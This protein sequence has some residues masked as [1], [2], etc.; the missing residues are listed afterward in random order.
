VPY[1]LP[2]LSAAAWNAATVGREPCRSFRWIYPPLLLPVAAF[3]YACAAAESAQGEGIHR[4][5]AC[6]EESRLSGR[7]AIRFETPR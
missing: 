3:R 2:H 1:A 5:V 7:E 4:G 6:I